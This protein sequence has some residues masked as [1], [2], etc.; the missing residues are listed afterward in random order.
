MLKDALEFLAALNDNAPLKRQVGGQL[1]AKAGIYF[2]QDL[3]YNVKNINTIFEH[4]LQN[5]VS[6][7]NRILEKSQSVY[8]KYC[9]IKGLTVCNDEFFN[10]LC[11]FMSKLNA[12]LCYL[13]FNVDGTFKDKGGGTW[14]A[15]RCNDGGYFCEWL[16]N[17]TGTPSNRGYNDTIYSGG[18]GKDEL[19]SQTGHQLCESLRALVSGTS[20]GCLQKLLCHLL[21]LHDW[22]YS[23]VATVLAFLGAFCN[24]VII[25]DGIFKSELQS[26]PKLQS[27]CTALIGN[28]NDVIQKTEGTAFL[29]AMY[30]ESVE[31][32][33]K[34]LKG[35]AFKDYAKLLE[36]KLGIISNAITNV[37]TACRWWNQANVTAAS[38][39]GPFPYGFMFG[40]EWKKSRWK[41]VGQTLQAAIKKMWEKGSGGGGIFPDLIEALKPISGSS[42]PG[43][44]GPRKPGSSGTRSA[45]VPTVGES[46][47][48]AAAHPSPTSSEV[49]TATTTSQ[50]GE[51]SNNSVNET[52]HKN[53]EGPTVAPHASSGKPPATIPPSP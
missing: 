11:G 9:K 2:K 52:G 49:S 3:Q 44:D 38:S 6:L 47:T 31:N 29:V 24:E 20:G 42:E 23:D 46:G 30:Q 16:T 33:G 39:A 19:S 18:Y 35:D 34:L 28:L 40:E 27:V 51:S 41:S 43:S 45:S 12:S 22:Y 4:V 8:E 13:L 7:R 14:A 36:A 53:N 17:N 21:F 10:R 25:Y 37:S 50:S 5:A 48:A 1:N 32:Y 26:Y 15:S